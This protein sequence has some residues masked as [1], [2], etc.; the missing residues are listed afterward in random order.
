MLVLE[1]AMLSKWKDNA[2]ALLIILSTSP[3]FCIYPPKRCTQPPAGEI[4]RPVIKD[5]EGARIF[6]R[7]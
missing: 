6:L 1:L 7:G 5:A 4:E 2:G 3:G